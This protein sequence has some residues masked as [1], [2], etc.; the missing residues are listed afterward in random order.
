MFEKEHLDD[1]DAAH[2]D[3][4]YVTSEGN[5]PRLR[6]RDMH[7]FCIQNGKQPKDLTEDEL[8]QFRY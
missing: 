5:V 4:K 8:T 1:L 3:G 2:P 7:K 6:I